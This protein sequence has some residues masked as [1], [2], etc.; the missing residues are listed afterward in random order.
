MSNCIEQDTV[1]PSG[2]IDDLFK[3]VSK[4]LALAF[5]GYTRAAGRRNG[6]AS[7]LRDVLPQG[8]TRM[9]GLPS[10]SSEPE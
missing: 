5:S 3:L 1:T 10:A 4:D 2:C 7:G 6:R 8:F 9:T